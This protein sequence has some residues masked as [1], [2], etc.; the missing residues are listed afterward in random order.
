MVCFRQS[1]RT[2]LFL[3][4][5]PFKNHSGQMI[6]SNNKPSKVSALMHVSSRGSLSNVMHFIHAYLSCCRMTLLHM[7]YLPP[8]HDHF[9]HLHF[10]GQQTI[11]ANH[12]RI[13]GEKLICKDRG[14]V[15]ERDIYTLAACAACVTG[16]SIVHNKRLAIK[17]VHQT[18]LFLCFKVRHI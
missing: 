18:F 2:T 5:R 8:S 15:Q 9:R 16:S 13:K 11:A 12:K 17:V 6:T 7:M 1:E 4:N 10:C 14:H 3:V